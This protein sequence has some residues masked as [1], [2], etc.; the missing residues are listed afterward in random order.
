[1]ESSKCREAGD[2]GWGLVVVVVVV[3]ILQLLKFTSFIQAFVR[4]QPTLVALGEVQVL[5]S[6]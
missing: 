3:A 2:G 4:N 6:N 5:Y 1:M